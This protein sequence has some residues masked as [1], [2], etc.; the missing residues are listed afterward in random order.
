VL[1]VSNDTLY[2]GSERT[3]SVVIDCSYTPDVVA[4]SEPV[5]STVLLRQTFLNVTVLTLSFWKPDSFS[6]LGFPDKNFCVDVLPASSVYTSLRFV[7]SSFIPS[8]F[9]VASYSFDINDW[10]VSVTLLIFL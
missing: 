5:S 4:A 9:A 8:G 2:S 7:V 1:L 6:V 3:I 10:N